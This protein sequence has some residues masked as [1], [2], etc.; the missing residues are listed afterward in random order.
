[1]IALGLSRN[2][3]EMSDSRKERLLERSTSTQGQG[4]AP[5]VWALRQAVLKRARQ[6]EIEAHMNDG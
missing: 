1:M 2:G 3:A 5:A 6:A 4:K